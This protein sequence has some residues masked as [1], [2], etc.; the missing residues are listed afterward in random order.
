MTA[1]RLSVRDA[2]E[3]V[4]DG[5]ARAEIRPGQ[6]AMVDAVRDA[7]EERRHLVVQAGTGTGKTLGYLVPIV[8]GGHRAVVA[9]ATK[10]LQDQ[11]AQKDLPLIARTLGPV[12]GRSIDWAVL[13][14]RSN[15]VCL[16]RLEE[17]TDVDPTLLDDL[18]T[19]ARR[20]IDRV[21]E[22]GRAHV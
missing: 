5:L 11:I 19:S 4:T 6:R 9:T 18:P 20:Q 12:L 1:R 8:I 7:I 17:T 14:G 2:L 22:I 21:R 10:A 15:Y 13:K 16:Q 3:V